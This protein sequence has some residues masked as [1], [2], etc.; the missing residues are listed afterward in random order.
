MDKEGSSID[1]RSV[2]GLWSGWGGWAI[3]LSSAPRSGAEGKVGR[4]VQGAG[5]SWGRN[6]SPAPLKMLL[7][8]WGWFQPR[9]LATEGPR[10]APP[11]TQ[12]SKGPPSAF[13]LADLKVKGAGAATVGLL[14]GR[15]DEPLTPWAPESWTRQDLSRGTPAKASNRDALGLCSTATPCGSRR[16][17]CSVASNS[18]R[19][20][21]L[22][23]ARLCPSLSPRV[24]S[25]SCPLS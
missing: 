4:H 3:S 14:L 19:V 11:P 21:G 20:R 8:G 16:G 5:A 17:C 18:M 13:S 7:G 25:N 15:S 24:C 22:Q 6:G 9:S 10:T 12:V 1:K 2:S 23:P